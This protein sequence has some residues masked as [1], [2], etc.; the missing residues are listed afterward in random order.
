MDKCKTPNDFKEVVSC[1][2]GMIDLVIPLIIGL[3]VLLFI[4]GLIKYVTAGGDEKARVEGR[5]YIIYGIIALF[6][7]VSVWGLVSILTNTFFPGGTIPQL[8]V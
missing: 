1:F 2:T 4:W 8:K 5:N 6:V 3:G 7:M